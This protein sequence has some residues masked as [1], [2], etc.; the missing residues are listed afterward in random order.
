MKMRSFKSEIKKFEIE[1]FYG[2]Y[3]YIYSK[4]MFLGLNQV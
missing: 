4:M 2:L 3:I 1:M